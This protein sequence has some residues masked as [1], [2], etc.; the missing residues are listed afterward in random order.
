MSLTAADLLAV[1]ERLGTTS[2]TARHVP[3]SGVHRRGSSRR[4]DRRAVGSWSR[5][6]RQYQVA[7]AFTVYF[8]LSP[9]CRASAVRTLMHRDSRG[10][11]PRSVA[12]RPA[13]RITKEQ[14][15][16]H[17][18]EGTRGLSYTPYS[19]LHL[20]RRAAARPG[21]LVRVRCAGIGPAAS[22][23]G[24]TKETALDGP[25][26]LAIGVGAGGRT[27]AAAAEEVDLLWRTAQLRSRA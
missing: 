18:D 27:A 14:G 15:R 10:Q 5:D 26:V 6:R 13:E 23:L 2:S 4:F 19:P 11:P 16:A 12:G 25:A 8:H 17:L 9:G 20:P 21:G 1:L 7:R 24:G 22:H 3:D